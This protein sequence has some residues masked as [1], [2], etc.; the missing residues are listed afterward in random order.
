MPLLTQGKI[1]F[2]IFKNLIECSVF[3]KYGIIVKNSKQKLLLFISIVIIC[4]IFIVA[5][6][7]VFP[8]FENIINFLT[9]NSVLT[10]LILLTLIL[11][12]SYKKNYDLIFFISIGL[13]TGFLMSFLYL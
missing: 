9:T 10:S 6:D 12:K 11:Y 4:S 2:T 13:L 8:F 5:L 3:K 7:L 1:K